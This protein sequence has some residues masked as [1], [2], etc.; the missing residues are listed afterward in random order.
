MRGV[1]IFAAFLCRP[2][3]SW[4]SRACPHHLSQ[5]RPLS[6]VRRGVENGDT[7]MP[8][9][10]EQLWQASLPLPTTSVDARINARA[11]RLAYMLPLCAALA[12]RD[13]P[14]VLGISVFLPVAASIGLPQWCAL[15][16]SFLVAGSLSSDVGGECLSV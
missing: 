12:A 9:F 16:A 6:I 4:S 2:S 3:H 10:L 11:L 13:W 8:Q 7:A 1:I 15:V 14:L 5:L